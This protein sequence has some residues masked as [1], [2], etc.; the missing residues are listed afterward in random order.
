ML[1]QLKENIKTIYDELNKNLIPA[2]IRKGVT[3]LNVEGTLEQS[4]IAYSSKEQ[5]DSI[6]VNKPDSGSYMFALNSSGYYESNNKGVNNSYA[7]CKVTF[8]ALYD[9][10]SLVLDCINY[11]ESS[12]DFGILSKLDTELSASNTVDSATLI[13]KSFKGSSMSNV[14]RYVYNNISQGEHFIYI[15]FRKDG[16]GSSYNDSFQF[17]VVTHIDDYQNVKIYS[18]ITAMNN[19]IEQLDETYA[20]VDI[21]NQIFENFYKYDE[22]T[23]T[24]NKTQSTVFNA[25]AYETVDEFKQDTIHYGTNYI[26]V[27]NQTN[28]RIPLNIYKTGSTKLD[29]F[30]DIVTLSTAINTGEEYH[31]DNLIGNEEDYWRGS[32]TVDLTH[33][34]F[35]L[36]QYR[37][38]A[39][40]DPNIENYILEYESTDGI[41][42][43]QSRNTFD[44]EVNI[45]NDEMGM[46]KGNYDDR[47][48]KFLY[49][50]GNV[51]TGL[52][53][54]TTATSAPTRLS[55]QLYCN[56]QEIPNDYTVY[57]NNGVVTGTLYNKPTSGSDLTYKFNV[58]GKLKDMLEDNSVY[59]GMIINLYNYKNTKL[60]ITTFGD[61]QRFMSY[62]GNLEIANLTFGNVEEEIRFER[63]RNLKSADIIMTSAYNVTFNECNNLETI[64]LSGTIKSNSIRF[65]EN[66]KLHSIDI[67]DLTFENNLTSLSNAFTNCKSLTDDAMP[68][69]DTSL[70][71]SF[72]GAFTSCELL[73]VAPDYDYSNNKSMSSMFSRCTALIDASNTAIQGE[74]TSISSAF[75]NC[76][77]L[78][79]VPQYDLS[80]FTS[81]NWGS[82]FSNCSS[83]S[84]E[85]LNNIL[86]TLTT[87]PDTITKNKTLKYCGLSAEQCYKCTTLS[88]YQA[89]VDS[90]WTT[91]YTEEELNQFAIN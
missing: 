52:Y 25:S 30:D 77:N 58:Y 54:K 46:I 11:A 55:N 51:F 1:N 85:S 75:S 76:S 48:G 22:A 91:G 47:I 6:V 4:G 24:W 84:D 71:T 56:N 53:Y 5:V 8:N 87:A 90:G 88:N 27:I 49:S 43:T 32:I 16:S 23:K 45:N 39:Y 86:A 41:T 10:C 69:L 28:S 37:D 35:K 79:T 67:T 29:T 61:I 18:S 26:G 50:I 17:K 40:N 14:Q 9:G 81:Y 12:F 2:N 68:V 34:K 57:G 62:M 60:P 64:K 3:I 66:T 73:T 20:T 19:D 82:A 21:G 72:S 13:E 65:N 7:L 33:T 63:N 70:V 42:Y 59:N 15:K 80:N 89:L 38:I 78:V 74:L 36:E 83:L 44:R 31:I